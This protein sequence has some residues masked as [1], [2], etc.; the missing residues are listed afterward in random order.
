MLQLVLLLSIIAE[1]IVAINNMQNLFQVVGPRFEAGS[2]PVIS[3]LNAKNIRLSP[4]K[5]I[6]NH[7]ESLKDNPKAIKQ[8][9]TIEQSSPSKSSKSSYV[10]IT[11]VPSKT[12]SQVKREVKKAQTSEIPNLLYKPKFP[13]YPSFG[14]CNIADFEV[15]TGEK[16]GK[17]GFGKVFMG[18]HIKTGIPVAIKLI[19]HES[20]KKSPK[21]VENEETI[22]GRLYNPWVAKFYCTMADPATGDIY[23]VLEYVPGLNLAKRLT[24]DRNVPR[25]NIK[26]WIAEIVLA[27]EYL[28]KQ[29]VV[30]R[31]LKAE[32]ILIS[33]DNHIRLIDFG[34]SV[35]DCE[36]K[37]KNV[38]GTLEY[39]SPEMAS[40]L[41][42][43]RAIDFYS[44]GVLLFTLIAGKLP[45]SFKKSGLEKKDFL[46]VIA[47]GFDFPSTGDPV[48]DD[49]ISHFCD[50]NPT[51]RWGLDEQYRK[52][53]QT[54]S[55]FEGI[56]WRKLEEMVKQQSQYPPIVTTSPA[57]PNSQPLNIALASGGLDLDEQ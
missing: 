2:V 43:G 34:L 42:H 6:H 15:S 11:T 21:H 55:F 52:Q 3:P 9:L 44:L 20:I 30:Y 4:K 31:D 29:C 54:H 50:K 46:K 56:D 14:M 53:I 41:P 57:I 25:E 24:K 36:N 51:T 23:F 22:H 45:L 19:S 27:L 8:Q 33:P 13:A 32:N 12:N 18:R 49:L 5:I 38:A 16:L 26:L 47:K 48:A 35:F 1:N 10:S 40:R 17:G 37:L 39:T 7:F 28:H